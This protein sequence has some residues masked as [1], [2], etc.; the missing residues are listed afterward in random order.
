MLRPMST[1]KL[2]SLADRRRALRVPVRGVAVVHAHA[3][4][5]HGVLSNLSHSGALVDVRAPLAAFFAADV[6]LHLGARATTVA[7]RTVRV[8]VKPQRTWQIAVAFENINEATRSAIE[9]TIAA[10]LAAARRRPILVIDDHAARREA[11]IELLRER[12]C[13][14]LSPATPLDAIE[15]LTRPELHVD[16]C[17]LAKSAFRDLG[18][19]LEDSFPWVTEIEII[20]DYET[21]AGLAIAAWEQTPVARL[22]NAIG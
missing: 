10:A 1:Q 16:V 3:G 17:L 19:V 22:G 12:G 2:A 18:H 9:A 14:P 13:T 11:L 5:M 7:A 4:P 15:M 6:E 8:E 21:S 20:D